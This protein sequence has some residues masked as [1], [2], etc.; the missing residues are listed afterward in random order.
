[1]TL[2]SNRNSCDVCLQSYNSK[3]NGVRVNAS[4]VWCQIYIW[5]LDQSG[6]RSNVSGVWYQI[7]I[8]CLVCR[9]MDLMSGV[10]RVGQKTLFLSVAKLFLEH[11]GE[12]LN[13]NLINWVSYLSVEMGYQKCSKN[14][15]KPYKLVVAVQHITIIV[16]IR[17]KSFE[18]GAD[19]EYEITN[20]SVIGRW[21]GLGL[22]PPP[23]ALPSLLLNHHRPLPVDGSL[24]TL[25]FTFSKPSLDQTFQFSRY[26]NGGGGGWHWSRRPRG[27]IFI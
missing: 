6:V 2:D 27:V 13:R 19:D 24:S 12:V 23:L 5:C 16:S 4:G 7:Y 26:R 1:M 15:D 11:W 3:Q 21:W 20:R 25:T 17:W 8:W 10:R 22:P 14:P 9:S 18:G